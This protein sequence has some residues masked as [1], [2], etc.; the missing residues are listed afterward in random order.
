MEFIKSALCKNTVCLLIISAAVLGVYFNAVDAPF[1]LDDP[2]VVERNIKLRDI[3]RFF[4]PGELFSARP[5]VN[6]S[7][8]LD[9]RIAGL[10]VELFHITNF[11]IHILNAFLV[12]FLARLVF[13]LSIPGETGNF[14]IRCAAPFF[15][16]ALFALHP[17]QSQAVIYISQRAALMACFF[18]LLAVICFILARRLQTQKQ[19]AYQYG[20]LFGLCLVFAICAFLSKKNAASIPLAILLA[21]LLFF[22]NSW[23]GWKKKLPVIIGLVALISLAFLWFAGAFKGDLSHLPGRI[24]RLTRETTDISRWQYFCT[25]LTVI[26]LYLKL[27]I[28]PKGLSIDHGH[29]VNDGFF[30]GFTPYAG[31]ILLGIL[32]LAFRAARQHKVPAFAV[33]W[34]FIAL[35][36]ESSIIPIRDAMFEHRI[37]L[38]FPA[39]GILSAYILVKILSRKETALILASL[40][41]LAVFAMTSFSRTYTWEN[42]LTLWADAVNKAPHNARAWNNYG[43]ALMHEGRIR[44]AAEAYQAAVSANPRY[45]KPYCNMGKIHAQNGRLEKA[46]DLFLKSLS[47]DP[48]FAEAHN[49]L[50]IVYATRG[51]MEKGIY[52]FEK[53]LKFDRSRPLTHF[54][55]GKAYLDANQPQ[56]SLA[57]LLQAIKLKPDIRAR[58]YYLAGAAYAV[59]NQPEKAAE[60]VQKAMQRGLE[61]AVD[62]VKQDPRF[63]QCRKAVLD[64]LSGP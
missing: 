46:E 34:F 56:K 20:P 9:Y 21:E 44:A 23:A 64:K 7:F 19:P 48:R 36:V 47:L 3:S 40:F 38:A 22:D 52:H 10:D 15:A 37:Y 42:E 29:P 4:T 59:Q 2:N 41:I 33:F 53:T 8:A 49:N 16:A 32:V 1:V 28:F 25:Q 26:L 24:D 17:V 60:W 55:L 31:L 13:T 18:Y 54:N 11:L 6:L 62:D 58:A 57:H 12:F 39:A 50:A 45:S 43:N 51:K 63:S 30:E 27:I 5:L 35:S 14:S 61:Q